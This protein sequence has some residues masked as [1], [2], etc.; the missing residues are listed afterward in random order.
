MWYDTTVSEHHVCLHIQYEAV[1]ICQSQIHI[2]T[3]TLNVL[4]SSALFGTHGHTCAKKKYFF[5]VLCILE[6][7]P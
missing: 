6:R 3:E 4:A 5:L 2:S 1:A 7:H